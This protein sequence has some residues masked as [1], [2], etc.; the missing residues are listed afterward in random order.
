MPGKTILLQESTASVEEKL[1]FDARENSAN[2]PLMRLANIYSNIQKNYLRFPETLD[3][4]KECSFVINMKV[5][6]IY[7]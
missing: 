5:S 6:F 1:T 7:N 2:I 4:D 3:A